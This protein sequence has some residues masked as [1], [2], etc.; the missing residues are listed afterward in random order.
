MKFG[1]IDLG[2]N[3][4]NLLIVEQTDKGFK[5]L[6]KKK[7]PVKLG[8]DGINNG[9]ITSNAQ[10]RG[11]QILSAHLETI[12]KFE[13]DKFYAFA[14]SAIRTAINGIEYTQ[15]IKNE[16]NLDIQIIS[17]DKEAELIY[18]GV[19]QAVNISDKPVLIIDIGGGSV[20]FIIC[21]N[22]GLLWKNSFKL[23]IARLLEKFCPS[24]PV[25]SQEITIIEEYIHENLQPLFQ[26]LRK[27]NV[28][29]LIGSSGSFDNF[30][31]MISYKSEKVIDVENRISKNIKLEDFISLH[32][33]LVQSTIDER[34]KMKGLELMRV[35][36]IVLASIIVNYII[37]KIEIRELIQSEYA[38]KEG[39]AYLIINNKLN[40]LCE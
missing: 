30:A 3:T 37:K 26:E 36:M 17:G 18:Y 6:T 19:S 8:Q 25:K 20:E 13:V 33:T 23:G 28:K 1:I 10:R 2:T 39:A 24:N 9:I 11:I 35:E 4:F 40:I 34:M 14:T 29:T 38:L 21:N 7:G 22:E 5:K 31:R 16:L 27:Y 12:R 32:Q 15:K